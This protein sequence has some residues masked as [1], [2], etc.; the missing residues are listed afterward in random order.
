MTE[1]SKIICTDTASGSIT[2]KEDDELKLQFDL[3]LKFPLPETDVIKIYLYTPSK[4]LPPINGGTAHM[5]GR[6]F[7]LSR[8]IPLPE[9]YK[10]AISKAEILRKNVFTEQAE[11][12]ITVDFINPDDEFEDEPHPKIGR[13]HV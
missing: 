13:A 4:D 9:C 8:I 11:Q 2:L 10:N 12:L 7:T 6:D 3:S 5:N 1:K